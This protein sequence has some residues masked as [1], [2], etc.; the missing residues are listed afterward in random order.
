MSWGAEGDYTVNL[1]VS[2]T[3]KGIV[4]GDVL[5]VLAYL[6]EVVDTVTD[7]EIPA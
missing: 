7:S 4:K 1:S 2:G 5:P 6:G 3:E